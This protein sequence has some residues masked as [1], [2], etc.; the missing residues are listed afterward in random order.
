MPRKTPRRR[1]V[2]PKRVKRL[3]PLQSIERILTRVLRT[4][5]KIMAKIDELNDKVTELQEALDT[6]QAAV[7]AAIQA[8]TDEV[9]RL[10]ALIGQ[11]A[12]DEQLQVAI[13]RLNTIKS[14]LEGTVA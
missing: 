8:L 14:D 5:E 1:V 10:T 11:G 4:Q 13:D 3:T 12:T 2:T 6:E 9:A 7:A